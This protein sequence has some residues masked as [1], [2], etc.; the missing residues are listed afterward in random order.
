MTTDH[1]LH[2]EAR[3]KHEARVARI[4]AQWHLAQGRREARHGRPEVAATWRGIAVSVL[5]RSIAVQAEYEGVD[6]T[7]WDA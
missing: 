6:T 3:A 5:H 7:G 2:P 1:Y 4:E